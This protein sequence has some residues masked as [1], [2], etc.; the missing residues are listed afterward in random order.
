M[1][2]RHT[3]RK[4]AMQ[5]L[6]QAD[7]RHVEIEQILQEFIDTS[8][9]LPETKAWTRMLAENAWEKREEL[10]I[11]IQK[12]A[13]DWDITRINPVDKNVL[14]LALYELKYTDLH[15]NV[16]LNEAIEIVK[17]YSSEESSKFVNGILGQYVVDH[18]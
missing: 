11:L 15:K 12:Y 18:P 3:G 8:A 16:V 6:Y 7:L 1:G 14:R 9:Y 4:L 10:D 13:I 5:S 2:K 17:K